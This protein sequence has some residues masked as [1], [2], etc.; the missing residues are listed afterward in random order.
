MAIDAMKQGCCAIT[1]SDPAATCT[2]RDA[3]FHL[4]MQLDEFSSLA[5]SPTHL[6]G[7]A[8]NLV[9]GSVGG[10]VAVLLASVLRE[11]ACIRGAVMAF[12]LR[13]CGSRIQGGR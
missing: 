2:I 1:R 7:S 5:D 6:L 13:E 8:M 11:N 12:T 9:V 3:S 4:H 10:I